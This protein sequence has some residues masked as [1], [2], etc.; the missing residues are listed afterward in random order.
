[1]NMTM[2]EVAVTME[3]TIETRI[4][5]EMVKMTVMMVASSPD[6]DLVVDEIFHSDGSNDDD[7]GVK[8]WAI[9]MNF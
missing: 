6:K 8:N 3:M 2:L 9:L 7:N 1:M 4:T 5:M